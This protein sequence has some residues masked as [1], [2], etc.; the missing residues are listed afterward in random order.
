MKPLDLPPMP[1]KEFLGL[2]QGT[3][4]YFVVYFA[5]CAILEHRGETKTLKEGNARFREGLA[6]WESRL[7]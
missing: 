5:T 6:Q 7:R 1:E 3:K 2:R 4:D